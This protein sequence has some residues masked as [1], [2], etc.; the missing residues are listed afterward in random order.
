[1][2]GHDRSP[3]SEDDLM[4]EMGELLAELP[5]R[6]PSGRCLTV[7]DLAGFVDGSLAG[8]ERAG[9]VAHL[10]DC[11]RCRT[12]AASL[13]RATADITIRAAAR[14]PGRPW[15]IGLG[16]VAAASAAA[17]LLVITVPGAPDLD[18]NHRGAPLAL[19]APATPVA[20]VG[21]V[22]PSPRFEWTP[23]PGADRYRIA[24][25]DATGAVIARGE[26]DGVS[27][28]GPHPVDFAVGERLYWRVDARIGRGRWVESPLTPFTIQ[29]TGQ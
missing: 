14:A 24:V 8:P 18:T 23:V 19:V 21:S 20:P 17:A 13:S 28:S 6:A 3:G 7:E 10:A 11:A 27:W 22:A 9:A 16:L 15:R 1:M 4:R 2:Q 25:Y 5:A 12:A 29:P 26:T